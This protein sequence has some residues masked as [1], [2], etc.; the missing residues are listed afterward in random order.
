LKKNILIKLFF[1]MGFF[2]MGVDLF[3]DIFIGL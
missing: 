1:S 2:S 3:S